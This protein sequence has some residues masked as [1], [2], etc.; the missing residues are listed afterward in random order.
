[1]ARSGDSASGSVLLRAAET[2]RSYFAKINKIPKESRQTLAC[3]LAAALAYYLR[4]SRYILQPQLF[5]ED[6]TVWLAEGFNTGLRSLAS[7][8]NGFLHTFERLFGFLVAQLPLRFAPAIFNLT[9][10]FL[11]CLMVYYLFSTRTRILAN[12]YE[13][14]FMLLSICL[15]ANV[16]ECFFNFTHSI[17]LL[18][19]SGVLIIV[20]Q[21]PGNRIVHVLEKAIFALSCFALP[22]AWFYL[23]IILVERFKHH[24]KATFFLWVAG[25]G[26]MA[27]LAGYLLSQTE[28]SSVTLWSLFSKYTL[29][30]IYNQIIIPAL[31]FARIDARLKAGDHFALL[32]IGFIIAACL[33]MTIVVLK[34]NEKQVWYLMF[35]F[36]MMTAASLK[37]PLV[38][39]NVGALRTIKIMSRTAAGDR[40]FILGI[41]ATMLIMVKFTYLLIEP[42]FRYAFI[43]IYMGFGLV[44]SLQFHSLLINRQLADLRGAYYRKIRLLQS[45]GTDS[46]IIPI[47]PSGWNI[48]LRRKKT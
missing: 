42:R 18:G 25:A 34:K 21:K 7:S 35:F 45:P 3:V 19:V 33:T 28:R 5:A 17:F 48:E 14:V 36:F 43:A 9:A 26:S 27:Q 44:T 11:F 30:E 22:F 31:R 40:Y 37:S 16:D 8:Y 13:R 46:I 2:G 1:M 41:L 39:P 15:I 32:S 10:L 4:G 38:G 47:N 24:K 12:T 23:P 20:A 6:G 29:L